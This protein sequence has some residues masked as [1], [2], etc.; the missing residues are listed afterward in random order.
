MRRALRALPAALLV[1]ALIGIWELYVELKGPT[2]TLILPP[3]HQVVK[4]LYTD[5][6]LLWSSF[7]VTAQEVVL[8]ILAATLSRVRAYRSRSTSRRRFAEPPIP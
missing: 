2:F 6:S 5:R 7:L 1:L 3:P 4:S 8:G